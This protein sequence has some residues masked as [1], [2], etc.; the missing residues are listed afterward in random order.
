MQELQF[1]QDMMMGLVKALTLL[2]SFAV[3]TVVSA[4]NSAVQGKKRGWAEDGKKREEFV[5]AVECTDA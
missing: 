4:I 5:K 2:S 1:R 3:V